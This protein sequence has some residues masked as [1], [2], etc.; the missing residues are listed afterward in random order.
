[1]AKIQWTW[2]EKAAQKIETILSDLKLN[3]EWV[4]N[5]LAR[6]AMIAIVERTQAMV[7]GFLE[8]NDPFVKPVPFNT[9]YEA[10]L[11][12]V[13]LEPEY[14]PPAPSKKPSVKTE[15]YV[16]TSGGGT[17]FATRC[18]LLTK[19]SDSQWAQSHHYLMQHYADAFLLAKAYTQN[20]VDFHIHLEDK[21]NNLWYYALEQLNHTS[22]KGFESFDDF[23]YHPSPQESDTTT[24]A[25]LI[26][27]FVDK[28]PH[29]DVR[30]SF[31]SQWQHELSIL[32]VLVQYCIP[33]ETLVYE[34]WSNM[35]SVLN[36]PATSVYEVM[37]KLETF[38]LHL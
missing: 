5:Y 8:E 14:Y 33:S 38:G 18:E 35:T 17:P 7:R 28:Y 10:Q 9:A 22:D 2:E 23:L 32:R 29:A 11:K 34:V 27:L 15:V 24:K 25:E 6:Q 16:D 31:M 1:M 3:P 26:F 19:L 20:V 30:N 36:V 21:V 13:T 12:G 37:K 4:G